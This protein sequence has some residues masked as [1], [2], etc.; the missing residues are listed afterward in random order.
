MVQ[1]RFFI[2]GCRAKH[3]ALSGLIIDI[4]APIYPYLFGC[5]KATIVQDLVLYGLIGG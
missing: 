1:G 5:C 4:Y 3:Q 2:E